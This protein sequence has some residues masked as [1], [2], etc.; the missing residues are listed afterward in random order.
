V[1]SP[2]WNSGYFDQKYLLVND[3]QRL[4][5]L[6]PDEVVNLYRRPGQSGAV[7]TIAHSGEI[8]HQDYYLLTAILFFLDRSAGID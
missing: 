8:D 3:C 4:G 7:P 6:I 5:Q 2:R 1:V